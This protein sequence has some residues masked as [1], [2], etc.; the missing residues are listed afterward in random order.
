MSANGLAVR[1]DYPIGW[2]PEKR[3][4]MVRRK[5]VRSDREGNCVDALAWDP[6]RPTTMWLDP[7]FIA[8]KGKKQFAVI[9]YKEYLTL[10]E[11]IED[12]EDLLALEV[13]RRVDADKPSITHEEMKRLLGL[14]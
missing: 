1:H 10:L 12:L 9:P 7:Q 4:R 8:T 5:R 14:D 11:K 3:T 6:T 2:L 13:A